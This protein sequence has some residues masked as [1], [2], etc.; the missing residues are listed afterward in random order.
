AN[1]QPLLEAAFREHGLAYFIDRRRPARHH[2]LV[3][4]VRSLLRVAQF[5]WPHEA[6][7]QL[8]KCAVAGLSPDEA[9]LL[10][11][12]VVEHRIRGRRA[13]TDVQPWSARYEPPA[14][15]DSAAAPINEDAAVADQLRL[16]LA[17]AIDPLT[18]RLREGGRFD[19]IVE[20]VHAC[21]R[22]FGTEDAVGHMIE[23]AESA[24]DFEA[25]SEHRQAWETVGNMLAQASELL[26]EESMTGRD[27]L[28]VLDY[29]LDLAEFAVT[30]ATADA[31]ILGDVER[32]RV[33]NCRACVVIG[34][35]DTIF[36]QPAVD[37][38]VLGDDDRR[39]LRQRDIDLDPPTDRQQL[40][41]TLLAYQA[42]TRA[43]DRLTLVRPVTSDDSSELSESV[44]WTRIRSMFD[45]GPHTVE[46][47]PA[48]DDLATPRQVVSRL[49][50][51]TRDGG[52]PADE[53]APLYDV[54]R[55][56]TPKSNAPLATLRDQAWPSLLETNRPTLTTNTI[57]QAFGDTLDASVSRLEMFAACPF[58]HY[59]AHLLKLRHRDEDDVTPRDL[60][61]LYH[62]V[63]QRLVRQAIVEKMRFLEDEG[64]A[65]RLRDMTGPIAKQVGEQLRGGLLTSSPRYQ[66]LLDRIE[67][68]TRQLLDSQRRVLQLGVL[69]PAHTE[70]EFGR[71]DG[72]LPPLSTGTPGG[73][74]VNLYGQIDRVDVSP[75]GRF[76]AVVD[77]KLGGRRLALGDVYYGLAMQLLT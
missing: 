54:L 44:Y 20:A 6:V 13:W 12:Y 53:V 30:P 55:D 24:G 9:D 74:R 29:G 66:H 67:R 21:M 8:I 32:T 19:E 17:E 77:Y 68:T 34:L 72:S 40:R 49:L 36:P 11:N 14:P 31:V 45:L 2:P 23:A 41:E 27:F 60:G 50:V 63:L 56:A 10:E 52:N 1:D 7:I 15:D 73:R 48:A 3:R 75:D 18:A 58:H 71:G 22:A 69:Q 25:A 51:W 26:G 16:R 33:L 47:T 4:F 62:G 37:D 43:S 5:G 57:R 76:A 70:L 39:T 42:F 61:I 64:D 35:S 59:A 38:T 28:A 46:R 65:E